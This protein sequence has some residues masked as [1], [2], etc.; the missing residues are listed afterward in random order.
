MKNY[1]VSA[2]TAIVVVLV[3]FTISSLKSNVVTESIGS[4]V[5]PD[6]QFPCESQGGITTCSNI[7]GIKSATTTPCA[8]RS[9]NATSTLVHASVKLVVASSTNATRWTIAKSATFTATT[10]LLGYA[11][12]A[13]GAQGTVVATSTP[14]KPLDDAI[15]FAPN[16]YI[17][18]GV[19][20][21]VTPG[22]AG[23]GFVPSG[24]CQAA[25]RIN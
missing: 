20:G 14:V 23:T 19:A 9:P 18:F 6:S 1:L 7:S 21:G 24:T 5:G 10:T 16:K 22:D 2:V 3:A 12:I 13:S 4:V 15:V 25:F 17:V 11:D 8:F